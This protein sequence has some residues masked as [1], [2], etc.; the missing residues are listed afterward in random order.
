MLGF[1]RTADYLRW[2]APSL[3]VL[4]GY[5]LMI[6]LA[7]WLTAVIT[8]RFLVKRYEIQDR[9]E[10][11]AVIHDLRAQAAELRR[12]VDVREQEV[13]DLK[14]RIRENQALASRLA[15][16]FGIVDV[17]ERHGAQQERE[18]FDM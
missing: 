17:K 18:V 15:L 5:P 11:Q 2:V 9:G 10:L 6:V 1:E 13:G 3:V 12:A 8:R 4:I 16:N 14:A 7:C